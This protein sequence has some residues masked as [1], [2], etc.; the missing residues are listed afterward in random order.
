M[1]IIMYNKKCNKLKRDVKAGDVSFMECCQRI[2]DVTDFYI[3]SVPYDEERPENERPPSTLE[4][5]HSV[6]KKSGKF[7]SRVRSNTTLEELGNLLYYIAEKND[8]EEAK[9]EAEKRSREE[10]EELEEIALMPSNCTLE[11]VNALL[12]R[13]V[14]SGTITKGKAER[15]LRDIREC[16][17]FRCKN[18][19]YVG[20][21]HEN[22][23]ATYCSKK[24]YRNAYNA[25]RRKRETGTY[26]G[27]PEYI[28]NTDGGND[29][30]Y[31]RNRVLM[32][33]L[34]DEEGDLISFDNWIDEIDIKEEQQKTY[35]KLLED[36]RIK[37]IR[38]LNKKMPIKVYRIED[39]PE[40]VERYRK[41]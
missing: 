4:N 30:W 38:D 17:Y 15:T 24:C 27:K 8:K 37:E 11:D 18:V 19:F 5:H 31:E 32:P 20:R 23:S 36:E 2:Q 28:P 41:V 13:W 34:R 25:R 21:G 29:L 1:W 7:K 6:D 22:E 33:D 12:D 14:N 9:K 35:R 26:L 40:L 16:E 3:S 39:E 10:W